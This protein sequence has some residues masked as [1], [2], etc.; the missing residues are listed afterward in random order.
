M[1]LYESGKSYWSVAQRYH[2]NRTNPVMQPTAVRDM[3]RLL[4]STTS[5]AVRRRI[6]NFVGRHQPKAP[7]P[8]GPR[9]A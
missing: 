3:Q 2:R 9:V 6:L 4:A 8:T 5:E 1:I 7:P